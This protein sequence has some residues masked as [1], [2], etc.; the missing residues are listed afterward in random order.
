[1]MNTSDNSIGARMHELAARLFPMHRSIT[2]QGVRDTFKELSKE[3]PLTVFEIPTGTPVLDWQVPLEWN[4]N[5]A[6]IA[7]AA[8]CERLIDIAD[9]TLHVT[10]YS[11]PVDEKMSWRELIPACGQFPNLRP[12][13]YRTGYFRHGFLPQR[14]RNKPLP[15]MSTYPL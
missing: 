7:D 10:N 6:V 1:M 8:T 5:D 2:G 14:T 13:P 3:I 9:N 4:I 11:Q 12:I 15:M